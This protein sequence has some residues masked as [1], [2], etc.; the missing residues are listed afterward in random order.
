MGTRVRVRK[1]IKISGVVGY[2]L[3]GYSRWTTW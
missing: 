1:E 3:R 2:N